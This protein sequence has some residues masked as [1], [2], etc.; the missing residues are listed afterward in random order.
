MLSMVERLQY[1]ISPLEDKEFTTVLKAAMVKADLSPFLR[2]RDGRSYY[3]VTAK[4]L[5]YACFAEN[6]SIQDATELGRSLQA[7]L[8]ERSASKGIR[9]FIKSKEE[10][11]YDGY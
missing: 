10:F 8:W 1:K 11:D 7:M 5:W 2:H 4:E 3:R 9:V 6:P